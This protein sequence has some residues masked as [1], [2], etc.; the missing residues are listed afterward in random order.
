VRVGEQERTLETARGATR[1]FASLDTAASFIRDIGLPRF[2]VDM[3]EYQ[4]GRLRRAR[5]DRSEA[6]KANTNPHETAVFRDLIM[7]KQ[8]NRR[9][10]AS[11]DL[12]ATLAGRKFKTILADPP[13]QF[14][15]RT[16]KVAPDIGD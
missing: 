10:E 12:R 16:G 14:Q 5:P 6:L 3:T 13:W 7:S 11:D 8:I 2:V 4:P 9:T 15:N 1:L